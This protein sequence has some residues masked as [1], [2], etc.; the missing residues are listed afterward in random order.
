MHRDIN[1]PLPDDSTESLLFIAKKIQQ[2]T[3][4]NRAITSQLDI[5]KDIL[6]TKAAQ[7]IKEKSSKNDQRDIQIAPTTTRD[8]TTSVVP[9]VSPKSES[10][11]SG[12][13]HPNSREPNSEHKKQTDKINEDRRKFRN[14]ILNNKSF[15]RESNFLPRRRI[16][17][18]SSSSKQ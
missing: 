5:L 14:T 16:E 3:E 1:L 4:Q 7:N 8:T 10:E 17:T 18:K 13:A 12:Y 15:Y 11:N 2:L 6:M 9:E